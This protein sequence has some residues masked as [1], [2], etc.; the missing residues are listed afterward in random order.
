MLNIYQGQLQLNV[1]VP[2]GVDRTRVVFDW[3]A[4]NPPV[5]PAADPDWLRLVDTSELVQDQDRDICETVQRNLASPA[6]RPGRYSV[7][8]ENGV[9]H[10][11]G[12]LAELLQD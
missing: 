12:L 6:Y 2:L 9:H 3:Y 11:H 5:D 1:V 7:R 10:F 8:R 4:T